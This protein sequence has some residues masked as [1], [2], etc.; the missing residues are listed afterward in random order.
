MNPEVKASPA[1][2]V[3]TMSASNTGTKPARTS[4]PA[5]RKAYADPAAPAV[6]RTPVADG[7]SANTW[8]PRGE[9]GVAGSRTEIQ[10]SKACSGALVGRDRVQCGTAV[11]RG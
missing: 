11:L 10:S 9:A 3:S 1:P 2:V 4:E 6:T 7:S 5:P 8:E